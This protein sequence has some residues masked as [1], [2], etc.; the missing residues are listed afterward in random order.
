MRITCLTEDKGL[1]DTLYELFG[2]AHV[3][4]FADSSRLNN[5]DIA[6]TE[7]LLVDLL[8]SKIPV[9]KNSQVNIAALTLIPKFE[10]AVFLM[11][12]GV[13]GYGNR[14]MLKE[15]LQQ[16]IKTVVT[17]QLWMP[18]DILVRL[19]GELGSGPK[20]TSSSSFIKDL[21]KREQEVAK[22][23]EQGLTNQKIAD[24]MYVSLRT[25]K[26]HLSSIYDKTGIK[27][28]LELAVKLKENA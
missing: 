5:A 14:K 26:A 21:S 9:F 22:F 12:S 11:Q 15:N 28:R 24:K 18:P 4:V 1:V 7:L 25:V 2:K 17:G 8:H 19:I 3:T 10:E 20:K 23:V 13:R 6:S 27:N 16:M